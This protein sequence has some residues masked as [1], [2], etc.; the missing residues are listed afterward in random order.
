MRVSDETIRGVEF[1][2]NIIEDGKTLMLT[3]QPVNSGDSYHLTVRAF[4]KEWYFSLGRNQLDDL[5]STKSYHEPAIALARSLEN[6]F[7][8]V[9][10]NYFTTLSGRLL[11]I[12]IE[13]PPIQWMSEK[14]I[15]AATG[16]W[17]R[18]TDLVTKEV[19]V[20]PVLTT[21]LQELHNPGTIHFS[22]P[23]WVTNTI[24]SHV[25]SGFIKFYPESD[26]P[27]RF[28]DHAKMQTAEFSV[29]GVKSIQTFVASKVWFLGFK[30]GGGRTETKVWIADP[31]MLNT[32]DAPKGTCARPRRFWTLRTGLCL[33]N[34]KTSHKLENF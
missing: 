1:L 25:D 6:R 31:W 32:S 20:C 34:M 5:P 2:R 28:P 33:A 29:P 18:L 8:N 3:A 10:P 9:D 14:G 7:L 24:R 26:L 27:T 11:K 30:A 17:A 23:A 15:M 4:E 12:D 13:W 19:A 21:H 22:R 16:V